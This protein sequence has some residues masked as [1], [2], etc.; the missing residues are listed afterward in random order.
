[1]T[2]FIKRLKI[3]L[4]LPLIAFAFYSCDQPVS[5]LGEP[6]SSEVSS[7]VL[8]GKYIIVFETEVAKTVPGDRDQVE[9]YRSEI[10]EDAEIETRRVYAKYNTAIMGFAAD[11]NESQ[12]ENLRND[13]R[14]KHIEPDRIVGEVNDADAVNKAVPRS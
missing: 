2:P 9:V 10:L 6:E 5:N 13:R 11:L 4:V 1:M 7:Q 12:L 3:G 14:I 8:K